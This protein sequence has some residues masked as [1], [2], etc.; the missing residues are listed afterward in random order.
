MELSSS[1]VIGSFVNS[2]QISNEEKE[3]LCGTKI[4]S[5]TL[6][7]YLKSNLEN[8]PFDYSVLFE[9][10]QIVNASVGDFSKSADIYNLIR[11][12]K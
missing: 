8:L 4:K 10:Q 12:S 1:Q 9:E 2:F 6:C 5:L 3:K 7:H 11:I